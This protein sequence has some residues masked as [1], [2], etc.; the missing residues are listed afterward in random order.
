MEHQNQRTRTRTRVVANVQTN[1]VQNISFHFLVRL[2]VSR[3]LQLVLFWCSK[4]AV[5]VVMC[6]L[7]I[8]NCLPGSE[9]PYPV[10]T[11]GQLETLVTSLH[12]GRPLPIGLKHS[13]EKQWMDEDWLPPLPPATHSTT[14]IPAVRE[15]VLGFY[16]AAR[17]SEKLDRIL[18]Q[19]PLCEQ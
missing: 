4:N 15:Y 16:Y 8:F 6:F 7:S 14:N 3:C 5:K 11:D 13:T 9:P 1:T 17:I 18:S 19:G 2:S 10:L 12:R